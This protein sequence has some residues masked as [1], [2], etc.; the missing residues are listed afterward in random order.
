MAS[1]L[2][3]FCKDLQ[4]TKTASSTKLTFVLETK[5]VISLDIVGQMLKYSF[6]TKMMLVPKPLSVSE[7]VHIHTDM[8]V[9][10]HNINYLQT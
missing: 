4:H 2:Q 1:A 9:K 3:P 7:P 10:R 5:L 6:F 8:K